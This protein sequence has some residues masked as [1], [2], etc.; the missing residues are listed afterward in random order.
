MFS[1]IRAI[2]SCSGVIS[3][4]KVGEAVWFIEDELEEDVG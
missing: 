4:G 3:G 2:R 1:L